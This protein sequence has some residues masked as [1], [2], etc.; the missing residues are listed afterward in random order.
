MLGTPMKIAK[1]IFFLYFVPLFLVFLKTVFTSVSPLPNNSDFGSQKQYWQNQDF[2][3]E[4]TFGKIC[5]RLKSSMCI[6][7]L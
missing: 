1:K 3:T 2:K 5:F 7:M 4:N 6:L